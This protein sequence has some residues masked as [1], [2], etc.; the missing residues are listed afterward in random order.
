M[1]PITICG[2]CFLCKVV[3]PSNQ[4]FLV[5]KDTTM[6][7]QPPTNNLDPLLSHKLGDILQSKKFSRLAI[8]KFPIQLIYLLSL[9]TEGTLLDSTDLCLV[10]PQ[11]QIHVTSLGNKSVCFIGTSKYPLK[12]LLQEM[13]Q[14]PETL[15]ILLNCSRNAEL[16]QASFVRVE[17]CLHDLMKMV[18]LGSHGSLESTARPQSISKEFLVN[19]LSQHHE[20]IENNCIASLKNRLAHKSFVK[21]EPL[22]AMWSAFAGYEK[23]KNLLERI[24][25]RYS[26]SPD[27]I[28]NLA[29]KMPKGILLYGPTGCGKTCIIKSIAAF[30]RYHVLYLKISSLFDKYLGDTEQKIREAFAFVR[31][32]S[33][34]VLFMDGIDILAPRRGSFLESNDT[35]GISNRTLTTLLNEMDGVAGESGSIVIAKTHNLQRLDDAILR[36][37]RFDY[38]IQV[39]KPDDLDRLE[40][41]EMYSKEGISKGE[42]EEIA[43]ATRGLS[44]AAVIGALYS[45]LI[46]KNSLHMHQEWT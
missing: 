14:V 40:I 23:V 44:G 35:T 21:V 9:G 28:K 33:P 16:R 42:K 5:T 10:Y 1:V 30:N 27:R 39:S 45:F 20:H 12:S 3:D 25:Y 13:S 2:Q 11:N 29:I 19:H 7:I 32:H 18:G 8:E 43:N 15:V 46:H 6:S 41:I 36:P 26:D 34:C 24:L 22:E 31:K 4:A 37:G 17:L 38:C